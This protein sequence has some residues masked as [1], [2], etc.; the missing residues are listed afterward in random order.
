MKTD[1]RRDGETERR[2]V[3]F[4]P[5]LRLSVSLFTLLLALRAFHAQTPPTL[6]DKPNTIQCVQNS[7]VAIDRWQGEYFNNPELR[8]LPAMVR[9]DGDGSI[10]FDWGLKG[11]NADCGVGE[12]DF[13][14]RWTRVAPFGAGVYRF[15]V[16]ADDGARLFIDGRKHLD[17]WRDQPAAIHTFEA[18]MTA[19][20][21]EIVFEY[22]EHTGSAMARLN[23]APAPCNAT[24]SPSRWRGEY[25][26]NRELKGDPLLTRDDGEGFLDLDWKTGSPGADCGVP[27]DDFSARW[28]RTVAFA[29][30]VYRFNINA[31][32]GV[33][34]YVDNQLKLDQWMDQMASYSVEERLA[35]GNHQITIEYYDRMG[36]AA[37]KLWW[38]RHP[39]F[40]N[41]AP[42]HWLGEYFDNP[43]LKGAP[44][45]AR[46]DGAGPLDLDFGLKS[47]GEACGIGADGFSVRWT[48]AAPTSAGTYRFTITADDGVRLFI[49]GK[50]RIDEWRN[51][52]PA[53]FAADVALQAGNH[54]IVVEYYDHTGGAVAKVD[55]QLIARAPALR[56][57]R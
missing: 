21:H 50:K 38:E 6:A 37:V 53:T 7:P 44:K 15:T 31:D 41:V 16:T 56:R 51:Q 18:P 11:P 30:G 17:Q 4:S 20:N 48:R 46:N 3:F 43:D 19:G 52:Q 1:R 55:W 25:F 45:M 22:Y 42:D 32:D 49:D 5:S 29:E 24:V 12:D 47:P 39:C 13:S 57:P 14:A 35:A 23:W 28:T 10:N 26:N 33:R 8:G 2:S 54:R 9:N 34:L 36:S 40:A 27:A